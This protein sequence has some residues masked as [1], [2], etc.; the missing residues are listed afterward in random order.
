MTTA[1]ALCAYIF[2]RII[3][4]NENQL[5][6]SSVG[7]L[8][9]YNRMKVTHYN[10]KVK[11]LHICWKKSDI[12]LML[13]Y[14]L[15]LCSHVA[16]YKLHWHLEFLKNSILHFYHVINVTYTTIL[17]FVLSPLSSVRNRRKKVIYGRILI[18]LV[19]AIMGGIVCLWD[20][21]NSKVCN[22]FGNKYYYNDSWFI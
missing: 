6:L 8:L 5:F 21:L 20:I 11:A 9:N 4:K 1:F 10:F 18:L 13:F 17:K 16:C 15:V 7:C 3:S 14:D 2:I 22:V 19:L 12:I